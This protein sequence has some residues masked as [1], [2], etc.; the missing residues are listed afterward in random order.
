MLEEQTYKRWPTYSAWHRPESID[1][2][3][4]NW[5]TSC[6]L[7]SVDI[8][9]IFYMEWNKFRWFPLALIEAAG[10][11]DKDKSGYMIG[12]LGQ[13]SRI[14]AYV[15]IY[16]PTVGKPN[17]KC[18]WAED[19]ASFRIRQVAPVPESEYRYMTCEEYAK[20]LVQLRDRESREQLRLRGVELTPNGTLFTPRP[21]VI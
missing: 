1:R 4:K 3:I 19:I 11:T 9:H 8:D 13:L 18:V 20:W 16:T 21:L 7:S 14:P 5:K 2:Y 15:V 12:A 6:S 17:P 10:E